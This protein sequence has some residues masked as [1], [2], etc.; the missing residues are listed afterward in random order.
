MKT[1]KIISLSDLKKL[2]SD[3]SKGSQRVVTVDCSWYL[4][5]ENRNGL[6]E[7]LD[8]DRIK[9]SAFFDIDSICKQ[10]CL[11]EHMLPSVELFCECMKNL[12]L[13]NDDILVI[14]EKTNFFTSPKV[15]WTLTFYGHQNVYLLKNYDINDLNYTIDHHKIE[16][17]S[18]PLTKDVE[19]NIYTPISK[20]EFE[21]NWKQ[22]IIDYDEFFE[23]V[24]QTKLN[25]YYVFDARSKIRF[26]GTGPEPRKD[27]QSGH[28]PNTISLPFTEMLDSEKKT[29]KS[30]E[31]LVELFKNKFG[32]DFKKPD[33]L[34]NKKGI[35]VMCGSGVTS[36]II[37][38][39]IESLI[40]VNITVKIYV[41]GW[42]QW[43]Q[44][45][46]KK[47]IIN[48]HLQRI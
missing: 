46:P 6:K 12:G 38:Y 32:L 34:K 48:E 15:A 18:T 26:D 7:F 42:C 24:E 8:N 19:N 2:L 37:K 35:I 13:K 36:I 22:H 39:A 28:I 41:G 9:N 1:I 27:L 17:L 45:A 10:N 30:K 4:P 5:D 47:Y 16:R 14:Y 23:L 11:E 40:K 3:Y 25:E 44:M 21:K 33:F 29:F 43:V 31:E 20:K